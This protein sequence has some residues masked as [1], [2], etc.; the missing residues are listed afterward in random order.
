[1][2]DQNSTL[3][4]TESKIINTESNSSKPTKLETSLTKSIISNNQFVLCAIIEYRNRQ[5]IGACFFSFNNL[6]FDLYQFADRL[7]EN[8]TVCHQLFNSYCPDQILIP[9]SLKTFPIAETFSKTQSVSYL[10]EKEFNNNQGLIYLSELSCNREKKGK[11][12]MAISAFSALY[13]RIQYQSKLDFVLIKP[14]VHFKSSESFILIAEDLQTEIFKSQLFEV[15]NTCAT[16][17]ASRLL[18]SLLLQP[19]TNKEQ[20]ENTQ[21]KVGLVLQKGE[22]YVQSLSAKISHFKDIERIILI[23]LLPLKLDN[24]KRA[25]LELESICK[26]AKYTEKIFS[27]FQEIPKKLLE[28]LNDLEIYKN[29]HNLVIKQIN[30]SLNFEKKGITNKELLFAVKGELLDSLRAQLNLN[31]EKINYF[32]KTLGAGFKLKEN[33]KFCLINKIGIE[34]EVTEKVEE[35]N[36]RKIALEEELLLQSQLIAVALTNK[37]KESFSEPLMILLRKITEIDLLLCLAKYKLNLENKGIVTTLPVFTSKKNVEIEIDKAQHPA[38]SLSSKE[39]MIANS[40]IIKHGVL[41]V[42]GENRSGKTTYLKQNALIIILSYIGSWV[43]AMKVNIVGTIKRVF[44]R[45]VN[46]DDFSKNQS[47][48]GRECTIVGNLLSNKKLDQ[49]VCFIDEFG[50]ATSALDG[51]SLCWALIEN[52]IENE[53]IVV[54]TTHFQLLRKLRTTKN[55]VFGKEFS[56]PN[57]TSRFSLESLHDTFKNIGYGIKIAEE[58]NLNKD[59]IDQALELR[60]NY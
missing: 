13:K 12:F 59:I 33:K 57:G 44:A 54:F 42:F 16:L 8:Y 32:V 37:I 7:D 49:T 47:T 18:K 58:L 46:H 48:F 4:S 55:K 26:L 19:G 11:F 15:L 52:F 39:K 21:E 6:S 5:E 28:D 50:R 43:P 36:I 10:L 60:K 38:W 34:K 2:K 22:N 17:S 45:F 27:F 41:L 53:A 30:V 20:I 9:E 29:L 3:F 24:V 31:K 25:K 40:L 1:M 23:I 56:N 51:V 35:F 14:K